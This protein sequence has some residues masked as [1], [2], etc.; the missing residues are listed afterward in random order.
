MK[1]SILMKKVFIIFFIIFA[2]NSIFA[3]C[4][5]VKNTNYTK[6]D[7]LEIKVVNYVNS[8]SDSTVV[9]NIDYPQIINF[10]NAEIENKVN[11]F[12][13]EEFNQSIAW[14]DELQMDSSD[15]AE[16]G[17]EMQFTFETGFQIEFN[18][19]EFL[20]IALSHY[21]FTGGAHGNYFALGY[22]IL[23]K[24]G[25]ILSL[26]DIIKEDSF[27][28]LAFE[29]EQA[30]LEKYEANSLIEAGL[31]ED[32]IEILDDQDFYISPG[33]LVLQFDPYEIGPW[34]MG[35]VTAEIPFEKIKDILKE[36]L[37]FPIH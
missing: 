17:T 19:Q 23:M 33:L 21:Q 8:N 2:T 35:E 13:E 4:L 10:E 34:V 16:L 11:L 26:K 20:S 7:T 31:F 25:S 14:F 6:F 9:I 12:L 36:N 18:S 28:L 22:N 37:P 32:E 1:G 29:C 15:F 30:I 5:F 24:D 3:K 27:D